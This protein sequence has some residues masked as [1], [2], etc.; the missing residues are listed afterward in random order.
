MTDDVTLTR[1]GRKAKLLR[2]IN[3]QNMAAERENSPFYKHG[4]QTLW[5]ER[6]VFRDIFLTTE[7]K[8]IR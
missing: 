3:V 4:A 1:P 2:Y 8:S 6:E 7:Q 5:I